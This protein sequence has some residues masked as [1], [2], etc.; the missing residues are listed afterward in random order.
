MSTIV[1]PG[2]DHT[3]PGEGP[4]FVTGH[5]VDAVIGRTPVVRLERVA[6][7]EMAEL[8]I[9]LES[10]I[11]YRLSDTYPV[12]VQDASYI[13]GQSLFA[14]FGLLRSKTNVHSK[15]FDKNIL[16]HFR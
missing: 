2:K 6:T 4:P 8:W 1:H 10:S 11:Q 16:I 14:D 12:P 15:K 7:P 5:R 3:A 13:Y 9:K